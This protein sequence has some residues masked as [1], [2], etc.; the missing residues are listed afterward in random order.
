M[1][2]GKMR[3]TAGSWGLGR[4]S[5]GCLSP[6]LTGH[7]ACL[8][9]VDTLLFFSVCGLYNLIILNLSSALNGCPSLVALYELV[10]PSKLTHLSVS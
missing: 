10:S 8:L 2:L 4:G 3:F 7:V 9:T 6:S 1:S 5:I